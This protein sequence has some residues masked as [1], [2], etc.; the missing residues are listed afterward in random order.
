MLVRQRFFLSLKNMADDKT[1]KKDTPEA[2]AKRETKLIKKLEFLKKLYDKGVPVPPGDLK[3][4]ENYG[5]IEKKLKEALPKKPTDQRKKIHIREGSSEDEK[6]ADNLVD[7]MTSDD[8]KDE[9]DIVDIMNAK[10][11]S[12]INDERFTHKGG[13]E[14]S[15]ADW[16][17]KSLI[18]HTEEFV[19]WIDS[20]NS[21]FQN[22]VP[23][24]PFQ[25]YCQQSSDWMKDTDSFY[26]Y[27]TE[28]QRRDFAWNE[29]ERI[30]ENS[31][32]FL[33]KYLHVKEAGYEQGYMDYKGKP[34][35]KVMAFLFDCG[36]NVEMGKPRQIAATT[37]LGGLA[38]VRT[39]TVKNY[40]IKMIA[41]DKDKVEEI[42]E[43]KIKY[44]YSELPEWLWMEPLN[45]R[46]SLFALG[47]KKSKGRKGGVNSRIQVVAPTVSAING[48][49]PPLVLI[50]E[51]G[52][53]NI[54][55]KMIK[56][57]RPTMFVQDE[58]TGK[59]EMKRQIW[60]WGTGGE[61]DKKGKAYAEE[62]ASTIEKWQNRE[63]EY[64]IIPIFFDWTTRPGITRAE[65][66][67]QKQSYTKSGPEAE[68]SMIQFRQAYPS[69]VEDMFLTSS[70]TLVPIS[71]INKRFEEIRSMDHSLRE[72]YGFFKPIFDTSKPSSEHDDVPF[73]IIGAEFVKTEKRDPRVSTQVFL[74]PEKG[75]KN[76]YYKGTD[77]I[78]TDN[79][80]SE[81]ASAVWDAQY[82]APVA[83]VHY[84]DSDHKYTFLQNLLLGIYYDAEKFGDKK[85]I[86]DLLESNIGTAYS[87]Y[88]EY[89]GF[90]RALVLN[91]ELP[92]YFQGGQNGIGIDNKNK[93]KKFIVNKLYELITLYGDRIYLEVFWNQLRNFVCTVSDKGTET[94]GTQDYKKYHDDALD[95]VVFSYIC[96]LSFDY[97]PPRNIE[98]VQDKTVTRYELKTMP[99]GDLRRVPVEIKR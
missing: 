70:K 67:R 45:D 28:D 83:V 41:Q 2:A 22:M 82:N 38:L 27:E 3:L 65:F 59:M 54:L 88:A 53:I 87:D 58:T 5:Y 71:Y 6:A 4:L 97:K 35:H 25:L 44:P 33:D 12:D 55:G 96:S 69:V 37:T 98:R 16:K 72:Q 29:M 21:G 92:S 68:E 73:K 91:S 74:H 43:D 14:I 57:A 31:L 78:A 66:L 17:P 94:W 26:D 18:Y 64:G 90:G 9:E 80:Y 62:Y 76:R 99:N 51:G 60:I 77:P 81:M 61:M 86:K 23:Y 32:Y 52:Y 13:K 24:K 47:Q 42:F 10:V 1:K 63:F 85:G 84:R 89:K 79:G 48:G 34:V 40:F 39:M 7:I 19:A 46:D 30:T 15:K 75:W 50:D 49:A 95:A 20:I 36:Y 56:E 11:Y 8:Y 93:R